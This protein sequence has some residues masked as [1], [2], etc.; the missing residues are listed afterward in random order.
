MTS[1]NTLALASQIPPG[2]QNIVLVGGLS[3]GPHRRMCTPCDLREREEVGQRAAI[4]D[5]KMDTNKQTKITTS[6]NKR[7]N[8]KN[9]AEAYFTGSASPKRLV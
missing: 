8:N 6:K 5:F 9:F 3:H 2:L 1:R 7:Q 4:L